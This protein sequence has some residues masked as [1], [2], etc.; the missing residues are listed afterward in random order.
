TTRT[1]VAV[2]RRL[3]F[4]VEEFTPAKTLDAVRANIARMGALLNRRQA[5]ARLRDEFDL[6][7]GAVAV[8]ETDPRPAIAPYYANSYTSGR[9]TLVDAI[10]AAS[11]L[12]NLG[13][14][15][16][17]RGTAKLPLELLLAAQPDLVM[18]GRRRGAKPALAHELFRH[19]AVKTL[20]AKSTSVVVPGKYLVCGT[21]HTA[22]AVELLSDARADYLREQGQ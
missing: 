3:G 20:L 16:G 14:M 8:T 21:P 1:T 4:Q 2:L 5:A 6:N 17:L 19:P 15:L 18:L 11:G 9:D 10:I 7:V 12:T 22:R 13:R